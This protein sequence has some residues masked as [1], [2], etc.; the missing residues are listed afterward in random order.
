M[1]RRSRI[2]IVD[3][4]PQQYR[5]ITEAFIRADWNVDVER[6]SP[7]KPAIEA[8]YRHHLAQDTV[9]LVMLSS[10]HEGDSCIDTLRVIRNYPGIGHQAIIV[11]TPGD[12]DDDLIHTCHRLGVIKCLEWPA[13]I[14]AQALLIMEIKSHFTPDGALLARGTWVNSSRLTIVKVL[15]DRIERRILTAS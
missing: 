6:V 11:L 14:S 7:G 12:Q 9:D 1:S 15:T 2:M 4:S 5:L 13:D 10:P 3:D 8:L